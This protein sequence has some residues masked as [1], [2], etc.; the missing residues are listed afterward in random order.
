[1]RRIEITLYCTAVLLHAIT[2]A[3]EVARV[4]QMAGH[5]PLG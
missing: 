2:V 5:P 4:L 3:V 1:M